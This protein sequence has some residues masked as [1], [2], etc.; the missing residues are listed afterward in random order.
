VKLKAAKYDRL[1]AEI[2]PRRSWYVTA[3]TPL[4]G[5]RY[6]M[7]LRRWSEACV[8]TSWFSTWRKDFPRR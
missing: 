8:A 1:A 6:S 2:Y 5:L 4:R 3:V 7:S